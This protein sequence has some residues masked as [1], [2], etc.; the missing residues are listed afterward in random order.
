M[1]VIVVGRM[2]GELGCA[3]FPFTL[4]PQ[5]RTASL[6]LR[7]H[8]DMNPAQISST[9]VRA[10]TRTGTALCGPT[11]PNCWATF[12]PQHHT[13]PVVNTAQV[14]RRP[15]AMSTA[16]AGSTTGEGVIDAWRDPVPS[17]P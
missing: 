4:L 11:N 15:A 14:C 13:S 10:G 3:R 8:V 9:F 2:A 17:A 7:T 6:D 5:H 12:P 1:P 16:G